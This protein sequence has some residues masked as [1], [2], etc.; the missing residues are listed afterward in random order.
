MKVGTSDQKKLPRLQQFFELSPFLQ[1]LVDTTG[2]LVA[3][4]DISFDKHLLPGSAALLHRASLH[5]L[6]I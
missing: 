3:T 6:T 1:L 5:K 4:A 2:L